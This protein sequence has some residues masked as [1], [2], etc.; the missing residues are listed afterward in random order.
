[1]IVRKWKESYIGTG[2]WSRSL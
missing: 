1:L 2:R